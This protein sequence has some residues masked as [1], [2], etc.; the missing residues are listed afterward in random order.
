MNAH[1]HYFIA[2]LLIIAGALVYVLFREP[3]FFTHAFV[4]ESALPVISL[5]DNVWN[6]ALRYLLPDALWC[7]AL[8]IYAET[9]Q[10]SV[11]KWIAVSIPF[12]MELAQMS[13]CVPGTFDIVDLTIYIIL[14]II[15]LLKWKKSKSL[16]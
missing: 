16:C 9:I 14:T 15:F 2:T 1:R 5:P 4:D 12:V 10:N 7:S 6:Y 13:E 11:V 8:L 3:V